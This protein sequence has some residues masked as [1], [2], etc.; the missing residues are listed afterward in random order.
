MYIVEY[1]NVTFE[2]VINSAEIE[3]NNGQELINFIHN[4]DCQGIIDKCGTCNGDGDDLDQDGLCDDIDD[5]IG[6]YDPCGV[7]NGEGEDEDS[8][9]ICDDSDSCVGIINEN[10]ECE[11]LG[12]FDSSTLPLNTIT[13]DEFGKVYYNV[14]FNIGGFQ[15][16]VEGTTATGASGGDAATAGFTVQASG[17]TVLGFSFSGASIPVGNGILTEMNL[18]GIP[19]GLTGI[20][21]SNDEG[22][23]EN[24]IY[25][26]FPD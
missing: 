18:A 17:S 7:C 16:N 2:G 13:T 4:D 11:Q 15:W 10:D 23:E 6:E 26:P 25:I 9:G 21:F 19:T 8:D 12:V 22:I 24:I 20:V 14:D 3:F 5:C 1:N